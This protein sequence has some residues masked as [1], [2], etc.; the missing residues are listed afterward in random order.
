MESILRDPFFFGEAILNTVHLFIGTW[1]DVFMVV[2]TY[3]GDEIFYTLFL[4]VLYWCY[5]KRNTIVIGSV[6]LISITLNDMV[7]EIFQNPRPDPDKLL[8]GFRALSVKYRPSDPGFPSGHTQ[9]SVSM[10]GTIM[11]LVRNRIILAAG[12]LMIVL[13]PYSRMYL[14]VH[15]F[16]DVIGGYVLGILCL[17]I[18]IP[19]AVLVEKHYGKMREV[20]VIL[21]LL[22]VPFILYNIL[23][24][25][26]IFNYMGVLS[27]FLA[28]A[29]LAKERIAFFPRNGILPTAVKLIIG[30][31][32]LFLVKEGVKVLLPATPLAGFMRYWLM[33]FWITF[34]APLIFSKWSFL[35]GKALSGTEQLP[36]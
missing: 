3:M 21:I 1:F 32:G 24:G 15:H 8:E 13:V 16:G 23:P 33:G 26:S 34:I 36:D 22:V 19:C 29:Y 17:V 25:R 35:G 20:F 4:P 28:G 14:G 11:Y 31:A 7:K 6:F 2:I 27:G 12:V 18:I 5:H 30:F 9:G 10:W